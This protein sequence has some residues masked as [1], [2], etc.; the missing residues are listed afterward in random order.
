MIT[1][2]EAGLSGLEHVERAAVLI[3]SGFAAVGSTELDGRTG[4]RLCL[5]NPLTTL[6]DVRETLSRL[7]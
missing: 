1:F 2:A 5:I 6:D 7:V 3:A 4:Y